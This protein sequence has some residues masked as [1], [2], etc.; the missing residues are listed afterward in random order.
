MRISNRLSRALFLCLLGFGLCGVLAAAQDAANMPGSV[1]LVLSKPAAKLLI[2]DPVAKKVVAEIATGTGPHQVAASDDGKL[3]FVAN[4]GEQ[5][6]GD[7]ISVIDLVARREL[8]RRYLGALRRP[9]GI[10][11]MHGKVYFTAENNKVVARYDPATDAIDWLQGTGQDVT[12][13]LAI[14]ADQNR[15]FTA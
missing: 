7:S 6:P 12:H 9:H 5:V 8:R 15:I 10:V 2:V 11:F 1:L 14:S 13:M 3:A 4:Y